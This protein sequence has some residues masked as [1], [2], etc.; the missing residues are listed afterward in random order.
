MLAPGMIKAASGKKDIGLQL[1]TLRDLISKDLKGTLEKVAATGYT[2]LEAA[3]YSEGKFYGLEPSELKKM[4]NGLG[5]EIM[6]SH[7]SFSPENIAQV[8]D[9][10]LELGASYMV[11]PWMS[12]PENPSVSDYSR[13]ADL[14]NQLGEAC[15]KSG[16]KFGYHNHD[17]EFVKIGD[18]TGYDILLKM[19]NPG[20][21]CFET[22]IYWMHYAN[23]DPMQ[24]FKTYPGRFELWHIKDMENSPGRGFCEVGEGIIPYSD[25][26]D[27]Y[28]NDAGMKYFFIEQD[29]CKLDPL[30]SIRI[31][32]YNLKKII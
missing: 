22:D 29:T 3:G 18:T 11:Y 20:T 10:H 8:I 21:V 2:W 32:Y 24:Y 19:T 26:F 15:N 30:E 28:S 16:L 25:Y 1:Y 9:A 6:S 14:F 13:Q 27:K 4:I 17:F 7:V 5:M 31:S 12:M 23:I